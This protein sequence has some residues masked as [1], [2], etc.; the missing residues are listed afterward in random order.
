MISLNDLLDSEEFW[1]RF[2]THL[3]L[4]RWMQFPFSA[5]P[6]AYKKLDVGL[7]V[8]SDLTGALHDL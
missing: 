5:L 1:S 4:L 6:P 8:M 2:V 3:H 7:L